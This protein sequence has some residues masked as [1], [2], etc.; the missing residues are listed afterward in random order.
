MSVTPD[1][2][3]LAVEGEHDKGNAGA[4]FELAVEG[5]AAKL[6]GP[7]HKTS[8]Q[9]AASLHHPPTHRVGLLDLQ[10]TLGRGV[11]PIETFVGRIA[12]R[13]LTLAACIAL[14]HRLGPP[15]RSLVAYTA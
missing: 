10:L 5:I 4:D 14:N 3:L 8:R 15:S 7:A 12:S 6:L 2:P 9:R 1:M 13:L 11:R